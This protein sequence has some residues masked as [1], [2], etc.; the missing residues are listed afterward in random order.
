VSRAGH[1]VRIVLCAQKRVEKGKVQAGSLLRQP[2][3]GQ[4]AR[5]DQLR[6]M[7]QAAEEA[8]YRSGLQTAANSLRAAEAA[9]CPDQASASQQETGTLGAVSGVPPGNSRSQANSLS[10]HY[11]LTHWRWLPRGASDQIARELSIEH[12]ICRLFLY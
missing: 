12:Q 5:R 7:N 8:H 1:A 9:Q 2:M 10:P 3:S 4:T 11:R 6:L